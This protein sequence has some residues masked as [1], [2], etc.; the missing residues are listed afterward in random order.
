[1]LWVSSSRAIRNPLRMRGSRLL[2]LF[3]SLLLFSA[4]CNTSEE[5]SFVQ[6]PILGGSAI[7][8]GQF[9]TVVAIVVAQGSR[10]MCTGTLVGPDLVLT[11]AHCISPSILGYSTQQQVTNET[12]VVFD[13]T[14]LQSGQFGATRSAAATIPH[15]SFGSPGDPD[16]GLIRLS[17]PITDRTPSRINLDPAK[18]P[19]G[20]SVT[21]VGYGVTE[22]GGGG[23]G[24]YL[25]NK[26][27]VSCAGTGASD[28]TFLCFNQQDGTGKCSGDSGGPS[29]ANINGVADTVVGI[30]SFGDQQCQYFGADMRVDA[31]RSF[32]AQNAPDLLCGDDGYCAEEC[33]VAGLPQ[34]PNCSN[35]A[36]AADCGD[37][38]FCSG[39][40]FCTPEPLAPGGLGSQC[41]EGEVDCVVGSCA[42]GPDGQ[43]CSDTCDPQ[44][45]DCPSG[46]D[47]LAAGD[48][49]ACWPSQG[50]NGSGGTDEGGCQ[51]G[52]SP[53]PLGFALLA[54][55]ALVIARRRRR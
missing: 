45:N 42:N 12:M 30:T 46:F 34:D 44:N 52:G 14:N 13:G 22:N 5:V 17:Q 6:A 48:T 41:G 40:G 23:R 32:L 25:E 24:M 1:M 49:G 7:T 38:E 27:S 26:S 2:S 54:L 8:Q 50:G 3:G 16:V 51:T 4:G 47:C 29:F 28:G 9:P 33:G 21:M 15:P 43:R 37:S 39:D 18:A 19:V 36:T 55:V 11:A 35:C 10:G 53:S 20:V 31:S